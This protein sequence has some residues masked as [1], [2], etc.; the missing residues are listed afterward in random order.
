MGEARHLQA[1]VADMNRLVKHYVHSFYQALGV[2]P[3]K[4]GEN[5]N[6]ERLAGYVGTAPH[7]QPQGSVYVPG[8]A[9]PTVCRSEMISSEALW[10]HEA[11]VRDLRDVVNAT[12]EVLGISL[13]PSVRYRVLV[14]HPELF[15]PEKYTAYD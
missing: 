7:R 10:T 11:R 9:Y 5:V 12:L 14:Q 6:S 8:W 1:P 4:L 2:P 15:D 13:R 3:Q